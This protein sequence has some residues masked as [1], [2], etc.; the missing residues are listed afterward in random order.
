VAVLVASAEQAVS[1]LLATLE[2][3]AEALKSAKKKAR[4]AELITEAKGKLKRVETVGGT[5]QTA[6]AAAK[7]D[8]ADAAKVTTAAATDQ[9]AA[10]EEQALGSILKELFK[11]LGLSKHEKKLI[12]Y[13]LLLETA[14]VDT[15]KF[16]ENDPSLL[17][18]P[19]AYRRAMRRAIVDHLAPVG[20]MSSFLRASAPIVPREYSRARSEIFELWVETYLIVARPGPTFVSP[21]LDTKKPHPQPEAARKVK[22][23]EGRKERDADGVEGVVMFEI[24]SHIAGGPEGKD[25]LQMKDYQQIIQYQLVDK[26]G[27]G[28]YT[29]VS[30]V[31]H[32]LDVQKSWERHLAGNLGSL[33]EVRTP[34]G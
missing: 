1:N 21:H 6:K 10:K 34:T 4:A 17:E 28:P 2:V 11:T 24:K 25:I 3:K 19:D 22:F 16:E 7:S 12:V 23:H 15:D 5:A 26:N 14:G 29:L 31:F 20:Q 9:A 33:H 30:Y 13:R 18:D 27:K 8:P 32:D